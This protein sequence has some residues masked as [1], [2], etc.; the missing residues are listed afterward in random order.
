MNL[1]YRHHDNSSQSRIRSVLFCRRIWATSAYLVS[2]SDN[3]TQ[4]NSDYRVFHDNNS[5]W[6]TAIAAKAFYYGARIGLD[7]FFLFEWFPR[8]PGLYWTSRA[9]HA[10]DQAKHRIIE[11]RRGGIVYDPYGKQSMLDGGIGSIRLNPIILHN[12]DWM[13]MS[14][15]SSGVCHQGFPVALTLDLYREYIDEIRTRGAVVCTLLGQLRTIPK[16]LSEVYSGYTEVPKL[17]LQV[18]KIQR[19]RVRKSRSMEN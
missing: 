16:E 1:Q 15:S 18:E 10:R 11:V 7:N 3:P 13:L 17:Y 2:S 19:P 12:T 8:S 6:R 4:D 14:A 5:L 9:K